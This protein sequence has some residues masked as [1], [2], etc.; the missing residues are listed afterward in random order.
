M[1]SGSAVKRDQHRQEVVAAAL[2]ARVAAERRHRITR[3]AAGVVGVLV[4]AGLVTAGLLSGRPT[5]DVAT[6]MAPDFTLTATDGTSA[7]LSALR[8]KPVLLYFSEGA[9]CDAC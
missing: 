4:V 2:K 3:I 7:T 1:T 9:G 6:R 8:G 5:Q